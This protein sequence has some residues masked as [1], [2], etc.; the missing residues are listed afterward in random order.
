[1]K[2]KKFVIEPYKNALYLFCPC[3]KAEAEAWLTKKKIKE[4]VDL[5]D[6]DTQD[7][8][9]F[10]T[11]AGNFI[12]M[13][14]YDDTPH[15]ISILVHELCHATFN[16]LVHAGVKEEAGHEEATAYLLDNMVEK[17]IKHLRGQIT[18]RAQGGLSTEEQTSL[19]A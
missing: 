15:G 10:Y 11:S 18:K 17:C 3:S 7:A 9:T 2:P 12:F 6:Y 8:V 1:M 14:K 16:V 13:H 4:H 5:D 19:G